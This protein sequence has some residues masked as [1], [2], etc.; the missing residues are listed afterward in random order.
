M[1]VKMLSFIFIVVLLC[2]TAKVFSQTFTTY[3]TVNGLGYNVISCLLEDQNGRIWIRTG[4]GLSRL[5][6]DNFS[7]NTYIEN[8]MR[9][10]Q[11]IGYKMS[12]NFVFLPFLMEFCDQCQLLFPLGD[13]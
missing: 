4:G 7:P 1:K 9:Y 3:T 12:E 8:K 2:N 6:Q 10:G 13:N 5:K 11:K